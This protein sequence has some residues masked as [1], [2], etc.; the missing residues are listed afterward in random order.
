MPLFDVGLAPPAGPT[1]KLICRGLNYRN[2][3]EETLSD[4][5]EHPSLFTKIG[6]VLVGHYNPIIRP[7]VFEHFDYEGECPPSAPM[8]QI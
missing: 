5:P 3:V 8:A 1:S 4:L 2:H 7:E 6:D